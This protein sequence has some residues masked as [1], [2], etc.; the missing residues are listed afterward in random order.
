MDSNF[1]TIND[2][3]FTLNHFATIVV[4]G[5][6]LVPREYLILPVEEQFVRSVYRHCVQ[7]ACIDIMEKMVNRDSKWYSAQACRGGFPLRG[8]NPKC[9][10]KLANNILGCMSKK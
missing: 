1:A 6:T 5:H 3:C 9:T 7:E 2:L 10:S 8:K 4:W